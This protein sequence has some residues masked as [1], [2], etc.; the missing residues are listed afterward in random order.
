MWQKLLVKLQRDVQQGLPVKNTRY[1][2]GSWLDYWL[3]Q[4]IRPDREPK[5]YE[6]YEVL[7]RVHIKPILGKVALD[8]LQVE[9]I[10]R[11]MRELERRKVGVRT[12][13]SALTRLRTA[14]TLAMRRG[15]LVRNV[16]ELVDVPRQTRQKHAPPNVE[17]L[18]RLL[19]VTRDDRLHAMILVA[20]GI[21]LR[22]GWSP[23]SSVEG[24]RRRGE[25][26]HCS[27]AR[28]TDK[29]TGIQVRSGAKSRAGQRVVMMPQLIARALHRHQAVQFQDR[30]LAGS[31]W[32]GPDYPDGKSVGYV[33]TSRIGTVMEPRRVNVYFKS[34]CK[35]AGLNARV[36]HGLRHDFGSLLLVAGVPTRVVQEMLGHA[37]PYITMGTY[38]H[39]S[40]EL[41]R[42]AA[43]RLD[44][45]LESLAQT[46][47]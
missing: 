46:A 28:H 11:W 42:D 15:H 43:D 29:Q 3:E 33:F 23:R 47:I 25:N 2:V 38:Q 1:T 12:R 17:D 27:P 19:D 9:D 30:L 13:Q 18:R 37:N 4:I 20:L 40:D 5:T 22:R 21:G 34:A 8:K 16:A 6:G 26:S 36:F 35:R 7:V 24:P 44:V 14:L 41:Q 31:L 10:E 45:V 39:V 32:K